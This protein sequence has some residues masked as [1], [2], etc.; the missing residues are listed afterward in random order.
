MLFY[1]ADVVA[2]LE[3]G[4]ENLQVQQSLHLLCLESGLVLGA[5]L[6]LVGMG[7]PIGLISQRCQVGG[8]C[9][10]APLLDDDQKWG[11]EAGPLA[12]RLFEFLSGGN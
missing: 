6:F 4:K 3:I 9:S 8:L 7:N 2:L 1:T 11:F 5:Q 10:Q 12:E